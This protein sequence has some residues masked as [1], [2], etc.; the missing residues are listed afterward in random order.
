[1]E[2]TDLL[3]SNLLVSMT[4]NKDFTQIL[5]NKIKFKFEIKLEVRFSFLIIRVDS[6]EKLFPG[7]FWNFYLNGDISGKTNG[8][9]YVNYEMMGYPAYLYEFTDRMLIPFGFVEGKDF[10]FGEDEL[11]Y[12]PAGNSND[13]A[14]INQ[15]IPSIKNIEW[16]NSELEYEGNFVWMDIKENNNY[17]DY[18]VTVQWLFWIRN[19]PVLK[20][21]RFKRLKQGFLG[22]PPFNFPEDLIDV[23]DLEEFVANER[24]RLPLIIGTQ[25]GEYPRMNKIFKEISTSVRIAVLGKS[26]L[27]GHVAGLTI[28]DYFPKRDLQKEIIRIPNTIN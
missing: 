13:L 1:M 2:N 24:F 15:Q 9:I 10:T 12:G 20:Y 5:N 28:Y 7:G 19:H 14:K 22:Y 17:L 6:I 18:H 23:V 16:I 11:F 21:F 26:L 8:V 3:N 25:F 4:N 27:S